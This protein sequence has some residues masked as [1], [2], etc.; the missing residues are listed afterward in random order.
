[1]NYQLVWN[2]K[3]IISYPCEDFS[4]FLMKGSKDLYSLVYETL[5]NLN[6]MIRMFKIQYDLFN[7]VPDF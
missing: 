6:N 2:S 1:M 3:N 7:C 5:T 4:E